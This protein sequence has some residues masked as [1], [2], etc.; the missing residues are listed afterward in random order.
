MAPVLLLTALL[1]AEAAVACGAYLLA[2][3]F[4]LDRGSLKERLLSI[5]PRASVGAL[6]S[7]AYRYLGYGAS[8]ST[9]YIDP[10]G[11]PLVS[12]GARFRHLSPR[13]QPVST[14]SRSSA[15]MPRPW[16]CAPGAVS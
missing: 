6:W 3:A 12:K 11:E 2:Y 7:I 15:P 13:W 10:V 8:G 14:R 16:W 9:H 1:S 5:V 4:F